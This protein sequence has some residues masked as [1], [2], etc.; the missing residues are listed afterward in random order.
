MVN[1]EEQ[2]RKTV[3]WRTAH[4]PKSNLAS[5]GDVLSGLVENRISPRQAIYGLVTEAWSQLLPVELFQHCKIVNVAGGRLEV[6]VDSPSY[7]YEM[8][9]LSCELI[10]ELAQCCPKARVREIKFALG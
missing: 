7:L 6:S 5:L 2:L 9:L 3:E 10:K 4:R 8:Q 1:S